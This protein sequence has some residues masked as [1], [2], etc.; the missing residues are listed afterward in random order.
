VPILLEMRRARALLTCLVAAGLVALP[1]AG[2]EAMSPPGASGCPIFP[3]DNVWHSDISKLPV[4]ARSAAW[5]AS[6]DSAST[7]LHP[8][9]GS[10]GEPMPYGIPY[11]VVGSSHADVPVDFYY[12]DESDAGPYP[13]GTDTPI[14][15]GSDRHAIMIDRDACKLYELFDAE[16]ASGGE[17]TAGSGAIWS[18]KSNALRPAGWTSADAAGLPIFAGLVRLDEVKAGTVD[19]AIR[20]TAQQTDKSYVWPARHQA[21]AANNKNLPPMGARFRLKAS[22]STSGFRSDTKTILAAM[23]E[24]GM[25]LADNGSDWYFTGA[26]SDDWPNDMLDELKSVPASAF[27]AVDASSLMISPNSGK[28][29]QTG[30]SGPAP[31]P[32]KPKPKPKP[33]VPPSPSPSASPAAT[34]TPTPVASS[35]VTPSQSPSTLGIASG[36][37]Y[38]AGGTGPPWWLLALAGVSGAGGLLLLGYRRRHAG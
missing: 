4:H 24:Y 12:P 33:S 16:Y 10:S 17:S 30:A 32:P 35:V 1:V 8:D 29:G 28:A 5:M 34:A 7:D 2:A 36:E 20:M 15:G 38:R 19:H 37:G 25:I 9:F 13:F 31:V 26:A 3:A 14:E 18:L 21:G 11:T 23:K 27:E 6:M 22:F